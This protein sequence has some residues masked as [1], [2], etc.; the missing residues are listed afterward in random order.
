R[1]SQSHIRYVRCKSRCTNKVELVNQNG[2]TAAATEVLNGILTTFSEVEK[3]S[4]TTEEHCTANQ[5]QSNNLKPR[6]LLCLLTA[7]ELTNQQETAPGKTSNTNQSQE[8]T[9]DGLR[10]ISRVIKE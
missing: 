1:K 6:I 7:H 3:Q 10:V 5:D 2:S 4:H 9:T 8:S